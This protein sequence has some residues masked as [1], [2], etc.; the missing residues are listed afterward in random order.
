MTI[1]AFL[2]RLF[3]LLVGRRGNPPARSSTPSRITCTDTGSVPPAADLERLAV[4][5]RH[6]VLQF[7]PSCEGEKHPLIERLRPRLPG[8]SVFDSGPGPGGT[9]CV[10]VLKVI[11]ERVVLEHLPRFLAAIRDFSD[12]ADRLCRRLAETHGFRP[13]ELLARRDEVKEGRLDGWGHGFH[14]LECCFTNARSGQV[15]DVRL[16]FGSEFGVLDPYFLARFIRTTA[17][18]RQGAVLLNDDFHGPR[19][20]MEVLEARGHLRMHETACDALG[21]PVFRGL[22]LSRGEEE[23]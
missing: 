12:T 4:A 14:G 22:I 8:H 7:P 17:A 9:T 10:T 18:H 3:R 21:G 5:G 20:V 15:V 23:R 1:P 13:E 2:Q 11:D 16:C 19:R 6:V